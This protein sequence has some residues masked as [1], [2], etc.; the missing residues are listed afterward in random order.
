MA[1]RK[2]TFRGILGNITQVQATNEAEA[3]HLAMVARWGGL[4]HGA[5]FNGHPP[6]RWAG[7]GL[8]LINGI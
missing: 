3:R 6:A 4:P 5:I 2:W 7:L 8:D 1:V